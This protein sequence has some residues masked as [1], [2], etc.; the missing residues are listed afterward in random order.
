M[1]FD[2]YQRLRAKGTSWDGISHYRKPSK[3]VLILHPDNIKSGKQVG[4]RLSFK[5]CTGMHYIGGYIR[6]EESNR[7][8]M[9]NCMETWE[10][11]FAQFEKM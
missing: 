6:D 11:I 8:W 5:V 3:I 10:R 2:K 7:D 9:K 1:V 4:S